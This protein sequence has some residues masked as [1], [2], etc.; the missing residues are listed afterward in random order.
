MSKLWMSLLA[1]LT[2]AIVIGLLYVFPV[3]TAGTCSGSASMIDCTSQ[4]GF[5]RVFKKDYNADLITAD[6][7]NIY[8]SNLALIE[9]FVFWCLVAFGLIW[10]VQLGVQRGKS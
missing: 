1:G 4:L 5:P 10:L 7:A 3:K 6:Q 8:S 2:G 9:D